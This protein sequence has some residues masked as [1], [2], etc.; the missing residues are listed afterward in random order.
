MITRI[1]LMDYD[2]VVYDFEVKAYCPSGA[3]YLEKV[4]VE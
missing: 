2:R 1:L 3:E 4:G